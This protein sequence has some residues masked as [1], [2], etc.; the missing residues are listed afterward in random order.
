MSTVCLLYS[1]TPIY[2]TVLH[3]LL[4]EFQSCALTT[5][6]RNIL[7]ACYILCYRQHGIL[8]FSCVIAE[9]LAQYLCCIIA[10]PCDLNYG[11]IIAA[12][13]NSIVYQQ[14]L[15]MHIFLVFLFNL[16]SAMKLFPSCVLSLTLKTL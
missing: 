8:I 11:T 1:Y 12:Y 16:V 2:C 4:T 13:A 15:T 9:I 7:T 14:Y 10:S 3:F 5:A 6:L